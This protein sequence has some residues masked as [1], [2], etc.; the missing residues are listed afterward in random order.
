MHFLLAPDKF[1]G[2]L[3]AQQVCAA[4]QEGIALA[5]PDATT[6]AVQLADGG[7]GTA[8]VL[9]A[10]TSG[11]WQTVWAHDPMNRP[12]RAG[13]G[14]SGDGT[15]A[16]VELAEASGWQTMGL[17]E[18]YPLF[19]NTYGTGQLIQKAIEAG[20]TDIILGI[21]GSVSTEGG[22][23]IAQA[24][25]WRF[26]DEKGRELRPEGYILKKIRQLVPPAV[27][28]PIRVRVA[29]DVQNP[30]YGPQGAAVVYGPQKKA[31][32]KEISL[33]NAGLKH[34]AQ[35]V[36]TQ[37]GHD[38][39]HVPGAG[40]AGGAGFGAMAFLDATLESGIDLVLDILHFDHQ[41]ARANMVL[42]GEGKLDEQTA[43]GKLL[44]GICRRAATHNVPVVALCGTLQL[45]PAQIQALGLTAAFSVLNSPQS[46]KKALENT[47]DDLCRATFNVVRLLKNHVSIRL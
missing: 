23:G 32:P 16:F 7:E 28:L 9:T 39:A 36:E 19:T 38:Y 3:T 47:H 6:T 25:G 26:L 15:T 17:S 20:A 5:L 27:P 13:F 14:L 11:T 45:R 44:A 35:L 34:L 30:L 21:G 2:S 46:L 33:L 4:M 42:T 29:C 10:A 41:L 37:L 18:R 43:Q 24:L 1:R 22:L 40:A 12:I 8:R 31:T